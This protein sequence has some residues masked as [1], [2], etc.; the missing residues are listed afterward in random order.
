MFGCLSLQSDWWR[1]G[2]ASYDCSFS[3][4]GVFFGRMYI[5]K[6]QHKWK[7]T[8]LKSKHSRLE[9]F[10]VSDDFLRGGKTSS[11]HLTLLYNSIKGDKQGGR[12]PCSQD[13]RKKHHK[14]KFQ[15]WVL[16][17]WCHT[18]PIGSNMAWLGA[19]DFCPLFKG[20]LDMGLQYQPNRIV[21]TFFQSFQKD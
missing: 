2:N 10:S 8:R 9:V 18:H 15:S 6:I 4:R 1:S 13:R 7:P 21:N 14:E 19:F 17:D 16:A 3:H 12:Q 20:I 11:P 5:I